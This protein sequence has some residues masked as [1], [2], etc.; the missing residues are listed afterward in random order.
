MQAE[1]VQWTLEEE[2]RADSKSTRGRMLGRAREASGHSNQ[3]AEGQ[4]AAGCRAEGEPTILRPVDPLCAK[5]ISTGVQQVLGKMTD[6]QARCSWQL[7]GFC[8]RSGDQ[9]RKTFL[10]QQPGSIGR[11]CTHCMPAMCNAGHLM[12]VSIYF[13][14]SMRLVFTL[15]ILQVSKL[16]RKEAKR[17]A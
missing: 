17:A 13:H 6:N 10:C 15:S 7:M 12:C 11:R 3:P 5:V 14:K 8:P 1:Q 16:K 2:E 9:E 4:R